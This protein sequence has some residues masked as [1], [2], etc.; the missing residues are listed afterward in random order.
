MEMQKSAIFAKNLKINML[1]INVITKVNIEVLH[2]AYVNLKYS[3]PKEFIMSFHNGL[4]NC[5]YPF[6]IKELGEESKGQF[7]YLG[8]NT[9][10]YVTFSVLIAKEVKRNSKNGE[11]LQNPYLTDY[12]TDTTILSN[13]VNKSC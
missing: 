3:L 13:L 4:P 12:N 9:E 6:I 7:I 2:I 5:D 10:K 1:K 8:Q 11:E